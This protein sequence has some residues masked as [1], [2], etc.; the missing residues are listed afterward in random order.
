MCVGVVFCGY[1]G[2]LKFVEIYCVF[3]MFVFFLVDIV[4]ENMFMRESCYR[5]ID[6]DVK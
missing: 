4:Y 2:I 3:Y 6:R 1:K 5:Y